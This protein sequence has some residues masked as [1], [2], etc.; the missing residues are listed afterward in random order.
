MDDDDCLFPM[1]GTAKIIPLSSEYTNDKVTVEIALEITI[2]NLKSD[3][4]N[5]GG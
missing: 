3:V 2:E 5:H 1:S 4:R